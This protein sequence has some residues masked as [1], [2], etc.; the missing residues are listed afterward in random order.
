MDTFAA[1]LCKRL[2]KW[3]AIDWSGRT[4]IDASHRMQTGGHVGAIT[5][6]ELGEKIGYRIRLESKIGPRPQFE[7]VTSNLEAL[8][9][10]TNYRV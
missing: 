6:C 1:Q 9:E 7:V 4:Q 3:N 8:R 5:Q 2:V 10:K